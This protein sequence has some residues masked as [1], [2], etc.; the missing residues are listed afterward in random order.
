M[1]KFSNLV[2][3]VSHPVA[4]V[5]DLESAIMTEMDPKADLWG[6]Q[7]KHSLPGRKRLTFMF[8]QRYLPQMIQSIFRTL[9]TLYEKFV[10][11]GF[12]KGF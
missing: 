2:V 7:H 9:L 6:A 4:I 10:I 3:Q 1:Q 8:R 11:Q 12:R 5:L